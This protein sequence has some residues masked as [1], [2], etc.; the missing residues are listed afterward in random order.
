[1][2]ICVGVT[3][4]R[5]NVGTAL[6]KKGAVPLEFIIEKD[7][8]ETLDNIRKALESVRPDIIVNTASKTD[9]TWCEAIENQDEVIRVN[10]RGLWNLANVADELKIPVVTLS[11]DHVFGGKRGPYKENYKHNLRDLPIN[12][13]GLS[14]WAMEDVAKTF[15]DVKI[16]RTSNLFWKDD[17]RVTWYLDEAY[18][19]SKV[20]VPV[21]QKRSFMY[22]DHFAEALMAY[23]ENYRNMPKVL[24]ISG[25]ETV[26]YYTFVRAFADAV[27][28]PFKYKFVRKYFETE[29]FPAKRPKRA[30]LVTSL[31]TKLRIPQFNYLD[32][33]EAMK[34]E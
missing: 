10:S 27:D 33:L 16:V 20:K 22:I 18:K 9:V 1:M 4:P 5:G 14:K 34:G 6:V 12:Y 23:I 29:K 13:Y 15:N 2:T 8:G 11:T 21:F 24:N 7:N 3:G 32:G 30:G 17:K 26:D 25:S 31:S 19:Q 28:F